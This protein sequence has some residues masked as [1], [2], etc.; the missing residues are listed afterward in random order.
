MYTYV[1]VR[2][3]KFLSLYTCERILLYKSPEINI[4]VS[5]YI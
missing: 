5:R 2:L 4:Y 3:D 1:Y